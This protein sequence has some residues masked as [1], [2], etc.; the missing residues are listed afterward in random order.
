MRR[1]HPVQ[2]RVGRVVR[3]AGAVQP[4]VNVGGY[5]TGAMPHHLLGGPAEQLHELL[6]G[7]RVTVNTLTRVTTSAVASIVV[8]VMVLALPVAEIS[9]VAQVRAGVVETK[10]SMISTTAA[11]SSRWG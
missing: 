2:L 5:E 3:N 9:P 6:L 8:G 7:L 4:G 1:G 10:S 11:G